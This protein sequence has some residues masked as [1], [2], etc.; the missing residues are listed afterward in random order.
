MTTHK[1]DQ[2]LLSEH[3]LFIEIFL[4]VINNAEL[5]HDKSLIVVL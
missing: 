5:E 4:Q 3:G 1:K 2:A